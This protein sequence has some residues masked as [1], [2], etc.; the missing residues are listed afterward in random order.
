MRRAAFALALVVVLALSA[1]GCGGEE[2]ERP[3]AQPPAAQEPSGGASGVRVAMRDIQFVP[4][5]VSAK[6]GQTITWVNEDSVPHDVANEQEG[7]EPR[8]ELF[9]QGGTFEFTP[10]EPGRISYVCTVHPGMDGTIVV[11]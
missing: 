10:R 6:V 9:N 5:E 4:R 8:S 3:A 7:R 1:S 11:G 2:E